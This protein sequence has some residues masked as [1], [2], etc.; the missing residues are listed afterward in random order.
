MSGIF[1]FSDEVRVHK[2]VFTITYASCRMKPEEYTYYR[3]LDKHDNEMEFQTGGKQFYEG[4]DKGEVE[5]LLFQYEMV[6]KS[7]CDVNHKF[8][9]ADVMNVER[10]IMRYELD[11]CV[12]FFGMSFCCLCC[13]AE[14]DRKRIFPF[15][16]VQEKTYTCETIVYKRKAV[17]VVSYPTS[18]D[19]ITV[20]VVNPMVRD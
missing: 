3:L 9:H 13:V 14:C 20:V 2:M 15:E 7:K 11:Y 18:V 16:R 17:Q 1:E 19:G 10:N 12:L 4:F 5:K 8:F 6:S